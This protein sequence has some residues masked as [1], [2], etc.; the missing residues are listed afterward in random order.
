[1]KWFLL[2][3]T[4]AVF[5]FA[6]DGPKP[7]ILKLNDGPIKAAL[8]KNHRI[9][10]ERNFALEAEKELEKKMTKPVVTSK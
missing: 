3:V 7:E 4:L 9:Y 8:K 2:L 1:M 10:L 6:K 5:A